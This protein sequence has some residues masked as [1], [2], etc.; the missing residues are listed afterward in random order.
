MLERMI[1]DCVLLG[2]ELLKNKILRVFIKV[3]MFISSY[4]PL[5]ILL[6]V[7]YW[8]KYN[9][10]SDFENWKTTLFLGVIFTLIFLSIISLFFLYKSENGTKKIIIEEIERPDDTVISYL[11]TYVIPIVTTN[12][13]MSSIIVNAIL[14]AL[15]GYF[16]IRLNLLY[17]N[18]LW[19]IFG[20]VSY[21]INIDTIIVTNYKYS[22]L[23][24]LK[25]SN[26]G[27]RGVF[28]A[29]DIFLAKKE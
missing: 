9:E 27:I 24:Q 10:K 8:E 29:N 2:G 4:F 5:Y 16:Y 11:M 19:S 6:L 20:Y 22:E 12:T 26:K 23:K 13:N 25:I 14:F 18:P 21:R 28:I 17:L 1:F 7:L 15:I 3:E